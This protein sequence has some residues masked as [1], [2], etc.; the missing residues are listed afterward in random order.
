MLRGAT[1][2]ACDLTAH[3]AS[4]VLLCSHA[5]STTISRDSHDSTFMGLALGILWVSHG[6]IAVR[7]TV[8]YLSVSGAL[9]AVS[10]L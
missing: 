10:S 3:C 9:Q 5:I 4:M 2:L 1:R 7:P 8:I 6:P